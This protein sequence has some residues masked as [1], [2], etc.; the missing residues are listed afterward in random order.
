[1]QTLAYVHQTA[2]AL[3]KVMGQ[4]KGKAIVCMHV[5]ICVSACVCVCVR[6]GCDY[7]SNRA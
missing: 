5:S 6:D 3:L 1:M 7:K 2:V 4:V